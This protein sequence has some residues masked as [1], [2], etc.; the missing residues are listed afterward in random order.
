MASDI[1]DEMKASPVRAAIMIL[2]FFVFLLLNYG[3]AIGTGF[4][5]W[6]NAI[7]VLIEWII[8]VV[9]FWFVIVWMGKQP[10]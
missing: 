6:Q 1:L 5:W 3:T 10:S 8:Y 2:L 4:D 7:L 9:I